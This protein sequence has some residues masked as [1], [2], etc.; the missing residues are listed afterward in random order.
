MTTGLAL[1]AVA[2]LSWPGPGRLGS[3]RLRWLGWVGAPRR[4]PLLGSGPVRRWVFA[5]GAAVPVGLLLGGGLGIGAAAAVLVLVERGLRRPADAGP[6]S[7]DAL[8]R[9]LPVACDLLAVCLAAG[10]PLPAALAAVGGAVPDGLGRELSRVAGLSRLGADPGRA[11]Q[12]APVALQPLARM[13]RRGEASGAGVVPALHALAAEVRACARAETDV[14]VRR[15]GVRV[16]APL[17]LCFL[18]A[19]VSLGVVPLVIGIAG[20]VLG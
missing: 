5:T 8:L 3:G 16:L 4:P 14:A 18:P 13:L 11:W 15:A 12:D 20:D 7:S 10:L 1:L 2:L 6:D 9:D 19:F 17:A